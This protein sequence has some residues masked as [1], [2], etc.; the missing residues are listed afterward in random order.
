[1]LNFHATTDIE[2]IPHLIAL[3]REAHEESRFS[4]IPFS[5]AKAE[6]IIRRAFEDD[7]RYAFLLAVKNDTPVGFAYCSVSEYH[8]GTGHLLVSIHN[9]NV[10]KSVR[11]GLSGGKAALGLFKGVLSWAKVRDAREVLFHVTSGVQLKA[12]HSLAKKMG[13]EFI[14]GSYVK[15]LR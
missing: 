4:Y 13:F 6:K 2:Y 5:E 12:S 1:M 7:R 3:S 14:G 8:I 9:I 11:A 10:S 15:T